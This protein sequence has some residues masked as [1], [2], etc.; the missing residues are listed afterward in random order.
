[1]GDKTLIDALEPAALSLNAA[2]QRDLD[3]VMALHGA[4]EA[5]SAGA[6]STKN[7]VAKQGKARYLGDQTLGHLDPG[8]EIIRIIFETLWRTYQSI[9]TR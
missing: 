6:E 4:Y 9:G 8:A 5:A 2:Q 3:L 1:L 7:F